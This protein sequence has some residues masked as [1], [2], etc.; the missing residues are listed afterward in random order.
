MSI[1]KAKPDK[2]KKMVAQQ[3]PATLGESVT[4][5]NWD[6][7][8]ALG[9]EIRSFTKIGEPEERTKQRQAYVNTPPQN[10]KL[11]VV[12]EEHYGFFFYTIVCVENNT[13]RALYQLNSGEFNF[14]DWVVPIGEEK[15]QS[16]MKIIK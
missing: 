3:P 2:F 14:I 7:H 16:E 8:I 5:T 11:F 1:T 4:V 6:K 12:K 15:K 10:A 9:G 13:N